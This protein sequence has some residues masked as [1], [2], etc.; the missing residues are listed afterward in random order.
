[1]DLVVDPLAVAGD[2]SKAAHRII[3][4]GLASRK[5]KKGVGN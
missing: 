4:P 5:R 2:E 1:M 3:E